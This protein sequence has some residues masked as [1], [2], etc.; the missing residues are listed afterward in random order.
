MIKHDQQNVKGSKRNG[1]TTGRIPLCL[2]GTVTSVLVIP[3]NSGKYRI[4]N[5]I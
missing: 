2:T 3:K 5:L 1:Q 4:L